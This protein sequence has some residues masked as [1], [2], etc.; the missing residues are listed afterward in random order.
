M[1]FVVFP[2]FTFFST[3]VRK[4]V[5]LTQIGAAVT[6]PLWI[7]T[8]GTKPQSLSL[9]SK[10]LQTSYF[11]HWTVIWPKLENEHWIWT[12]KQWLAAEGSDAGT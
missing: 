11:C 6:K 4:Q 8:K 9:T 2:E 1:L 12:G 3:G 5:L 10:S 7:L